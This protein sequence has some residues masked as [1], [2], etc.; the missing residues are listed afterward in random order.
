MW[1]ILFNALDDF[2]VKEVGSPSNHHEIEAV[3]RRIA[4]EA[5]HGALRISG[6]VRPLLA[7][8]SVH[9]YLMCCNFKAAVLTSNGY[10][11]IKTSKL[12]TGSDQLTTC[13]LASRSCRDAC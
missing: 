6:L 1:I 12:K 13:S 10:L 7:L 8:F 11:V 4:E 9:L 3:K 2:G 5:L